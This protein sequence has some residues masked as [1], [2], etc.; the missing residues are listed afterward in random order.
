MRIVRILAEHRAD[1]NIK[2]NSE[3]GRGALQLVLGALISTDAILEI[4]YYSHY[5]MGPKTL[6]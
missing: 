3:A 2:D 5:I 1:V 4:P 6:F